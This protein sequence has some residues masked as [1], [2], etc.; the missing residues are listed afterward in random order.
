MGQGVRDAETGRLA[1]S[2]PGGSCS[3]SCAVTLCPGVSTEAICPG[4][5]SCAPLGREEVGDSSPGRALLASAP[6]CAVFTNE[7]PE[8]GT[9]ASPGVRH[10]WVSEV[11][12]SPQPLGSAQ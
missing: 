12:A 8:E 2:I 5:W 6:G 4:G 11:S 9:A 3:P 7:E 1:G 10:G